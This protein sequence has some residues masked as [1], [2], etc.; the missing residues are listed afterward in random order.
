MLEENLTGIRCLKILLGKPHLS[1]NT[2]KHRNHR[3]PKSA[4]TQLMVNGWFGAQ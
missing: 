2:S 1:Q 3:D 4:L